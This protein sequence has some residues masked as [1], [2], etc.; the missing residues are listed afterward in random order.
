MVR[1]PLS[2][3]VPLL[4]LC[5]IAALGYFVWSYRVT[6]D[7]P[8]VV[9]A[10]DFG[11][12]VAED[13][14]PLPR[15]GLPEAV[16]EKEEEQALDVPATTA[17]QINAKQ[18][19]S[20][21]TNHAARPYVAKLSPEDRERAVSCL[22]IAA[23]YE[24]GGQPNDQRPV[25]QTILNR[26]RHPAFPATACGVVF[27]GQERRT[28]CQFSFTCDG[29]MQRYRPAPATLERARALAGLMLSGTVDPR[30]GLATHYHTDWV[31]PYWSSSLDK[32][33]AVNTHLFFRWKGY[34]GQPKAFRA[35]PNLAEPVIAKMAPFSAAHRK[36]D[37]E[38]DVDGE[39]GELDSQSADAAGTDDA[40]FGDPGLREQDRPLAA[41]P[42]DIVPRLLNPKPGTA[43]GRWTLDALALCGRAP[44]CRVAGW[45]DP[46]RAPGALTAATIARSPPDLVFVQTLRNREQQAYW[47]CAKYPRQGTAKCL[48]GPS[49]TARL[50]TQP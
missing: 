7:I 26:V 2:W 45:Q 25:I 6:N 9:A 23:I 50:L 12:L 44:L 36:G 31:V 19:F 38:S 34:W 4:T 24:A 1:L 8:A 29:S 41:R 33:T 18:P 48:G 22:A 10:Q 21:A 3:L 17:K 13:E 42:V 14:P 39:D 40:G 46:S 5:V 11:T 35:P 47:N 43:P 16:P 30:V 32:I 28:G 20:D 27:Q 37:R 15:V 49:E